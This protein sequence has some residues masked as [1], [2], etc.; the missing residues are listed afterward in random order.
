MRDRKAFW[1]IT[2][3]LALGVGA[4]SSGGGKNGIVDENGN[5]ISSVDTNDSVTLT[6]SGLKKNTQY[7]IGVAD[8][9]GTALSPSGGFIAS[10]DED[11]TLPASTVLQD[12]G[13]VSSS[14]LRVPN[15]TRAAT[16]MAAPA[17][18]S[19]KVT[20]TD[21][22]GA[23]VYET[24]FTVVDNSKV[25]C[26]DAAGTARGS[27]TPGEAVYASLAKGTGSLADG[28]YTCY[29]VSDNGAPLQED[30]T[31]SGVAQGSVTV[32]SGKGTVSLGSSFSSTP[33]N[34]AYDVVCDID[35]NGKF[36]RAKD[37]ISR[38]RRFNA[39]FTV[40][41]ANAATSDITGQI[42]ADRNGNYRDVFD[43]NATDTSIRDVWAW[44]SPPEKGA[45]DHRI[46]VRKYVVEHKNTWTDG[47]DLI[48]V[49]GPDGASA[50]KLDAV[51][52]FCTNEA[53]WLVWPRQLLVA[54][55]YDCIIDV[56]ADGKYT[57][58]VD[59]LD[60]WDL[61]GQVTCGMRVSDSAC[62]ADAIEVTEPTDGSS[63]DKTKID[64]KGTL[65]AAG[66]SGSVTI[67]SGSSS[68]RITLDVS[69]ATIEATLPLFHGENLIT[70][71]VTKT[72]GK[73]CSKTFKI[74]STAEASAGELFRAQ[75]TWATGDD[76]DLHVVQP[77]GT[78]DSSTDCYYSNCK[79]AA[80]GRDWG[81]M[82][83]AELDVD[84][85]PPTCTSLIENIW[86]TDIAQSGTY[87]VYVKAYSGT[88]TS[89]T[90]SIFVKGTQVATVNCGTLVVSSPTYWCKVGTVNW[91][92]ATTGSG[93]FTP[94]GITGNTAP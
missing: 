76:M 50:F 37:L 80:G 92:G 30:E 69:G 32:T 27:F 15:G 47:D 77:S 63:T 66:T 51:Q 14:R 94:S 68:N 53:P 17:T 60:Y 9:S 84:C 62:A 38:P 42:C 72:D 79:T 57:K 12:L 58:G 41:R 39:C 65:A 78:T 67:T 40:Q 71:A 59:F 46:G 6:L 26:S 74:T 8:P 18:G 13:V 33:P 29:V 35:G 20:V 34:N 11:G 81:N 23:K 87:T 61:T 22:T 2:I 83:H 82:G 31:L 7:N 1:V 16:T 85:I 19:Y 52:G 73:T 49:T 45:V 36:N 91:S 4:C 70:V 86:L 21:S 25:F 3:L 28:T 56:N 88:G 75:L 44:I 48:D 93:A 90:T 10:T 24:T 43:P 89:V 54:G 55:C 5:V 64:L